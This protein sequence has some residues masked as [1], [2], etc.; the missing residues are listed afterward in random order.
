MIVDKF[1]ILWLSDIHLRK[2]YIP[3]DGLDSEIK[4]TD[5][6]ISELEDKRDPN[7]W[8][9]TI[10][11][12]KSDKLK[13]ESERDT[14]K[15]KYKAV[16]KF[17]N[18]L[19]S[20]ITT[21]GG[22]DYIIISGDLAFSGDSTE[23]QLLHD[24]LLKEYSNTPIITIPGNHDCN[25]DSIPKFLDRLDAS[26]FE[27]R[28]NRKNDLLTDNIKE[29][30]EAFNP[31]SDYCRRYHYSE[32]IKNK[33]LEEKG[34]EYIFP[35][36]DNPLCGLIRDTNKQ[37]NFVLLNSAWFCFGAKYNDKLIDSFKNLLDSPKN[38]RRLLNAKA[39]VIEQ[40]GLIV[41]RGQLDFII[42]K[43]EEKPDWFTIV[44]MHHPLH[45]LEWG[46]QYNYSN[47]GVEEKNLRK[48]LKRSDL[49]LTGHEHI[50]I[51]SSYDIIEDKY[52]NL[53]AGM[54]LEDN[55]ATNEDDSIHPHNRF[56][57]IVK[58]HEV[59]ERKFLYY[60]DENTW[61]EKKEEET[62]IKRLPDRANFCAILKLDNYIV[63]SKLIF[64]FVNLEK[65]LKNFNEIYRGR[66][67]IKTEQI[68]EGSKDLTEDFFFVKAS[69]NT[70]Q[71]FYYLIPLVYDF[72]SKNQK[73]QI[74]E[75]LNY[76]IKNSKSQKIFV[77]FFVLDLLVSET[78]TD[79]YLKKT[80]N[81][82]WERDKFYS[83]IEE[84][85][86]NWFDLFRHEFFNDTH[87][88]MKFEEYAEISL[89]YEN[90]PYWIWK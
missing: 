25:W 72:T 3:L 65:N 82:K 1:K 28:F 76:I 61:R 36:K 50:P 87:K 8:G 42:N 21:E 84:T 79:L 39:L 89:F 62:E 47:K 54:F 23:Y 77:G 30:I 69:Q 64:D 46:E 75:A 12:L 24:L 14:R 18:E 17:F 67:F 81:S 7:L 4:K 85:L 33:F 49:F 83:Q 59:I 32:A 34:M 58:D 6:Q 86:S 53:K 31:Y 78:H 60:K 5:K 11:S 26:S 63:N 44:I 9:D 22:F 70:E 19:K 15:K 41:G 66:N 27:E 40:G 10:N 13:L 73:E 68:K 52:V 35:D 16:E 90:I 2:S 55:I 43:L 20:V 37:I 88:D 56:S 74:Y 57:I 80:N 71:A 48:I 29:F 38:L 51:S 45:W